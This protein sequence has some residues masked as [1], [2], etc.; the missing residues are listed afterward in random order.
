M[1]R[2]YRLR[3]FFLCLFNLYGLFSFAQSSSRT[4]AIAPDTL[5]HFLDSNTIY[6]SS[7]LFSRKASFSDTLKIRPEQFKFIGRT[8]QFQWKTAPND[9]IYLRFLVFPF[10]L[11]QTV[12]HY[13][14]LPEGPTNLLEKEREKFQISNTTRPDLFGGNAIHKSGSLA[15]GIGFGNNQSLGLNSALN[16]QLR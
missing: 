4:V 9:T 10:P 8:N 13:P 7:F 15:R 3:L 16:L 5:L 12:Q 14:F 6:T 11:N 1:K 2:F